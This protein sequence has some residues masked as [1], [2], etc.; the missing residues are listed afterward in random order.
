M[1]FSQT[2][3]ITNL[4]S[5]AQRAHR[6]VSGA[7]A[8]EKAMQEQQAVFLIIAADASEESKQRYLANA[9]KY[10]VPYAEC[11]DRE[12]LGACLGKECRAVAALLDEGF[13][14]KLRE[15]LEGTMQ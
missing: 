13:A 12:T 1:A 2:E 9:N 14:T 11:L 8:V 6:I 10:N 3:R 15:L 5:M 7:F 4:L